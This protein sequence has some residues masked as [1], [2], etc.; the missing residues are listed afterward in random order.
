MCLAR[1]DTLSSARHECSS[2]EA[3]LCFSQKNWEKFQALSPYTLI[4]LTLIYTGIVEPFASQNLVS[5]G[6]IFVQKTNI[7]WSHILCALLLQRADLEYFSLFCSEKTKTVYMLTLSRPWQKL[8]S[9]AFSLFLLWVQLILSCWPSAFSVC[10]HS[11]WCIQG[12][13]SSQTNP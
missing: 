7:W 3:V 4:C 1:T 11:D 13:L 5:R 9:K 12:N 2:S 10:S 6:I 8:G